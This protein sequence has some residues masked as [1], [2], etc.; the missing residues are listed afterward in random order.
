[1]PTKMIFFKHHKPIP[2]ISREKLDLNGVKPPKCC[3][4]SYAIAQ[5]FT[6]KKLYCLQTEVNS[7]IKTVLFHCSDNFFY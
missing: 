4:N 6:L 1:M 3:R 5:P 7:T 2:R